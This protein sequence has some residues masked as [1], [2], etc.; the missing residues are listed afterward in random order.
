MLQSFTGV[1]ENGQILWEEPKELP[2]HAKV[3]VTVLEELD[4]PNVN[5]TLARFAGIWVNKHQNE[6][7]SLDEH[8]NSIRNEWERPS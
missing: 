4:T 5:G 6:K 8:L 3:I 2:K 1:L 7:Q